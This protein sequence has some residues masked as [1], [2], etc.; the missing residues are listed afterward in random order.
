MSQY[1]RTTEPSKERQGKIDKV[2]GS[3]TK[4]RSLWA[5]SLNP[6]MELAS[7]EI[8]VEKARNNSLG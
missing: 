7:K 8:P 4:N 6:S 5:S 3:G 1:I 2:R